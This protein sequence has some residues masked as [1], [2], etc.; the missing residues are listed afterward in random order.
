MV[1]FISGHRDITPDEFKLHYSVPIHTIINMLGTNTIEFVVGDC[2]GVDSMAQDLLKSIITNNPSKKIKVTVYHMFTS[3][4]YNAEFPCVGGFN[5]DHERDSAMTMNSLHD[6][7]WVRSGKESSGTAQ[8]IIRRSIKN[9]F[10]K[11]PKKEKKAI[12]TS[13]LNMFNINIS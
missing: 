8:N 6:I 12:I 9:C 7:A 11:L 13:W 10:N 2:N 3:P 5:N 1:Y 4:R